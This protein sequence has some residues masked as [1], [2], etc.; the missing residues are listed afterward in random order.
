[1]R[2]SGRITIDVL[3]GLTIVVGNLWLTLPTGTAQSAKNNKCCRPPHHYR[4]APPGRG[5]CY[6]NTS[7]T[8][9]SCDDVAATPC[10]GSVTW[11]KWQDG[12]CRTQTSFD[13]T[14]AASTATRYEYSGTTACSCKNLITTCSTNS[15]CR[16]K[17]SEDSIFYSYRAV[18]VTFCGGDDCPG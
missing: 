18:T 8:F 17:F 5:S 12:Y 10:A 3:L 7:G 2:R 16:C 6:C 9:N 15:D 14:E 4:Y 11:T 1:M 13:C